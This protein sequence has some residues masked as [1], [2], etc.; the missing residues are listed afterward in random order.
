MSSRWKPRRRRAVQSSPPRRRPRRQRD[1][2]DRHQPAKSLKTCMAAAGALVAIDPRN[3]EILA[4]VSK[5][6]FDQPVRR[7]HR[8]RNWAALNDSI[9]KLLLNRACFAPPARLHLQTLHGAGGPAAEQAL[10][11]PGGQRR[12]LLPLAVTP[13]AATGARG[14]GTCTVPSSIRQRYFAGSFVD[15]GVDASTTSGRWVSA[16]PRASTSRR[17]CGHAA[18]HRMEAPH[19]QAHPT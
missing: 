18:Q 5:P 17:E 15:M 4:L 16:D 13:S 10:A 9:D 12:R 19:L 6:T 14:S 11:Q 8:R 2:V 3:G 1:A 7:R